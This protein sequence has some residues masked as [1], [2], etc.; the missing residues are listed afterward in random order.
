MTPAAFK[1]AATSLGLTLNEIA[2]RLEIH[3]RTVRKYAA[4]DLRVTKLVEMALR[5]LREK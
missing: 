1:N 3:P 4:G 2:R 5:G